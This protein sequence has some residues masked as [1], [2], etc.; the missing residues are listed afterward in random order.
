MTLRTNH[1]LTVQNAWL[2]HEQHS[3]Q[4]ASSLHGQNRSRRVTHSSLK[5]CV[6]VLSC[7]LRFDHPSGILLEVDGSIVTERLVLREPDVMC[8]SSNVVV[9]AD[10]QS[11][12]FLRHELGRA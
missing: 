1:T 3:F 6:C 2:A 11:I 5:I 7:D 9:R 12:R 10:S 4:R 8:A